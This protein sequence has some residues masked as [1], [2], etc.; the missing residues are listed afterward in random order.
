MGH[1]EKKSTSLLQIEEAVSTFTMKWF[2]FLLAMLDGG[3][4]TLRL[5]IRLNLHQIGQANF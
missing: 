4:K 5:S 3:G 2:F 1:M